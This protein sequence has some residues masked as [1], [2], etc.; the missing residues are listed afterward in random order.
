M[1]DGTLLSEI[2]EQPSVLRRLLALE[3]AHI[4]KIAGQVRKRR[5]AYIFIAA[6]GT[7][8][9]AA[10]YA[11]YLFGAR[12][13][14][15]V[16][17]AA[18]SLFTLYSAPPRLEGALVIGISQSGASPDLVAVVEQAR[19]QGCATLAITN[20]AASPLARAA[21]FVV[22]LHAELERS[23]A[24]T[25]TYS[26]E[27][28][29]LAMLSHALDESRADSAWLARVPDLVAQ[30]LQRQTDGAIT[31][32]AEY[33]APA[34]RCVV[35]GRGF[36]Y[37]TA[38]E[39]AL[40]LKELAYIAAEP[41]SS[42][43]FMHGPIALVDEALPVVV[44]NPS[45]AVF[46][47]VQQVTNE[48]RRR[49]AKPIIISDRDEALDNAAASIALPGEIPEWLSPIVAIVPGQLLAA[50]VCRARG[51]DPDR[52]RGLQKVTKTI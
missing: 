8:D 42:A 31:K 6:R 14:L 19:Q 47:E 28:F 10:R 2:R 32:A 13:R 5:P 43:D 50:D 4:E 44:V 25:K 41:Y 12:N 38:F 27:L 49:G 1:P 39:I 51:F 22:C 46:G 23:V 17:L 52:P 7:S 34:E 21:E 35:I 40:K 16:A 33:L 20:D 45:G 15:A 11:Q 9:N 36:N 26:A 3:S 18:P 30:A 29:A 37:A 24:A 48:V